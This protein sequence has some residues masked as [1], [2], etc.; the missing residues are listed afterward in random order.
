MQAGWLRDGTWPEGASLP[1]DDPFFDMPATPTMA[2]RQPP[3]LQMNSSPYDP[4]VP[5]D[6]TAWTVD[7][8]EGAMNQG[9]G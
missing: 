8:D 5:T 9:P 3:S 2:P 1:T 4:R 7:V 6:T